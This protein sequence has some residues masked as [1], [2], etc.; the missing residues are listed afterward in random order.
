MR[1][2]G[3]CGDFFGR[4]AR[5]AWEMSLL[6]VRVASAKQWVVD[7]VSPQSRERELP[8]SGPSGRSR[9]APISKLNLQAFWGELA[10]AVAQRASWEPE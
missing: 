9:S 1:S 6:S 4:P 2:Y 3:S 10:D 5:A 7:G 8:S